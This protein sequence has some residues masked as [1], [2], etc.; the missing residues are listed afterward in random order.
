MT[1][2]YSTNWMGPVNTQW[3]KDRG[4]GK[5]VI[6]TLTEDSKLT[7]RKA[8]ESFEAFEITTEYAAGRIDCNGDGLGPFGEELSIPPMLAEDWGRFSKWLNTFE[9]DAMWDFKDIIELYER[10]NPKITWA[11]GYDN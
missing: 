11:D 5:T 9:T 2:R 1:V 6:K 7:G 4:F 3:Y 10:A 8:G